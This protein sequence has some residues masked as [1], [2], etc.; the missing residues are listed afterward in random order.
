MNSILLIL[1][2]AAYGSSPTPPTTIGAFADLKACQA[3]AADVRGAIESTRK[4]D[5]LSGKKAYELLCVPTQSSP[6]P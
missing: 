3:A 1:V 4:A 5:G 6:A 2:F